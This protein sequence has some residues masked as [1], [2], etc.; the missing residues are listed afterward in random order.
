M[1]AKL[2]SRPPNANPINAIP[3]T[4]Q[5]AD[6]VQRAPIHSVE[7]TLEYPSRLPVE[8]NNYDP[9]GRIIGAQTDRQLGL[10]TRAGGLRA[11]TGLRRAPMRQAWCLP[12]WS[13]S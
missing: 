2:F 8:S 1:S 9:I 10:R 6:G 4:A 11:R 13:W 5:A 3:P 7:A 12:R